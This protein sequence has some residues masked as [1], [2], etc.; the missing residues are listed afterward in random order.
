M[1]SPTLFHDGIVFASAFGATALLTPL[2]RRA[3]IRFGVVDRPA[4]HKFHQRA[5]P[6]LGGLSVAVAVLIL[7]GAEVTGNPTVRTQILAI[8][9]G[10]LAVS[11]VGL[12]DDWRVLSALPRLG[13]QSGAAVGLWASGVRLAPTGVVPIDLAVTVFTVLAVTNSIN[14]LDNMDGLSAGTTAVIALFFFLVA[15]TQGQELVTAMALALAGGCL[16]FLPYN[17][18]PARIFLGDAGTLFLGFLLAVLFIK[19]KLVGYPLA[20]RAAVPLLLVSVP[21]FDTGLVVVSRWRAGRPIFR[22]STDHSSH[23]LHLMLGS[24]GAVAMVTYGAAAVTGMVALGLLVA[25]RAW[26]TWLVVGIAG[27]ACAAGLVAFERI[28]A[29][30]VMRG[31]EA[32][33]DLKSAETLAS[34]ILATAGDTLRPQPFVISGD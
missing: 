13:V 24:P 26:V 32:T 18:H 9:L 8:G 31:L 27:L 19:V 4:P 22:G 3:A 28:Y 34:G 25:D 16:G 10:G 2:A 14:L 29:G 17:F 11:G 6:Y 7:I 33:P 20:T 12:I 23:R 1:T 5:T 21:F 15:A 30:E